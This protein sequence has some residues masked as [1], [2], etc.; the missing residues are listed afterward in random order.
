MV[1]ISV[2]WKEFPKI[3]G[4][5]RQY[6]H[7]HCT[8]SAAQPVHKRGT[9]ITRLAQGP[10]RS[11]IALHLCAL[12][13]SLSSG[14]HMSHPLLL[15]HLPRT[16]STSCSSF[17]LPSTTTPEHAPQSGQ[18]DLLQE[19]LQARLVEKHRYQEPLWRENLLSDGNLRNTFST[20]SA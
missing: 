4:V 10:T 16:T 14:P 8:Y 1:V 17:I 5:C 11:R 6:T 2:S 13:K 3:D 7:K 9:H 18:N 12:E 20:E 15:S 19:P